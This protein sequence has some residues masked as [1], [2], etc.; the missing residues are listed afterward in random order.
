[1]RDASLAFAEKVT[2]FQ[3]LSPTLWAEAPLNLH[4]PE[5]KKS[6]GLPFLPERKKSPV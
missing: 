6:A 1:M 2:G 4:N 3:P 5:G